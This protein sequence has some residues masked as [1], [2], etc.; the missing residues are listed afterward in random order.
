MLEDYYKVKTYDNGKQIKFINKD[1]DVIAVLNKNDSGYSL[2][3]TEEGIITK[4]LLEYI[5]EIIKVL[6][7]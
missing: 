5:N 2:Y 3:T 6:K 4:D 7:W 1:G